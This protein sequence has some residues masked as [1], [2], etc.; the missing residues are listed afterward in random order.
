MKNKMNLQ[1]YNYTLIHEAGSGNPTDYLSRHPKQEE[2]SKPENAIEVNSTEGGVEMF[3]NAIT[4]ETE[5]EAETEQFVNSVINANLPDALTVKE[6]GEAMNDDSEMLE[7]KRAIKSRYLKKGQLMEYRNVFPELSVY[8]ELV[9]R[10]AKTVIPKKL[11]EKAV[12][13]AH[14]AHQGIA[15]TIFYEIA[16][17]FR[18]WIVWL[19]RQSS[20]VHHV[21]L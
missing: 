9:I 14:E 21:R 15:K 6:I 10:G 12:T 11:T 18:E 19:N 17:G 20:N 3:V 2:V 1:G 8:G 13:I 7:L 5:R 4:S 16:C